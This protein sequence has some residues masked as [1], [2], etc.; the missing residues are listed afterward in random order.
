LLLPLAE[1]ECFWIGL[2][3][4]GA[5]PVAVSVALE[6]EDGELIDV[7]TGAPWNTSGATLAQVPGTS[8]IDGIRRADGGFDPLLRDDGIGRRPR[9]RR[10]HFGIHR[11]GDRSAAQPVMLELVDYSTF[12]ART[13][14][15]A[16]EPLDPDAGYKGWLLP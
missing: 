10:L 9:S 1:G 3:F 2:S 8:V 13:G 7:L 14:R 12:A 4:S 16:P 5:P 15:P 6:R 11:V